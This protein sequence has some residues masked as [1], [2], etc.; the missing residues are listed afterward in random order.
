MRKTLYSILLFLFLFLPHYTLSISDYPFF[1]FPTSHEGSNSWYISNKMG[2]NYFLETLNKWLIGHLGDDFVEDVGTP[3][4]SVSDGEVFIKK[5]WPK[6]SGYIEVC[7]TDSSGVEICKDKKLNNHGWGPVLIIKHDISPKKFNSVGAI[8]E[9]STA[10]ENPSV[11]YSHYGHLDNVDSLGVGQQIIKGQQVGEVGLV[12]WYWPHLH[13]EIKDTYALQTELHDGVGVGYSSVN[14]VV[15]HHYSPSKFIELNKNLVLAEEKPEP[16]QDQ[17]PKP[18]F[19]SFLKNPLDIFSVFLAKKDAD[20]KGEKVADEKNQKAVEQEAITQEESQTNYNAQIINSSEKFTALPVQEIQITISAQNTGTTPWLQKNVSIN[21]ALGEALNAKFKHSSWLTNLRTTRLDQS[22][23]N[24][25]ETGTFS[26]SIT[27]PQTLGDHTFKSFL[28]LQ[29]GSSFTSIGTGIYTATIQVVEKIEQESQKTPVAENPQKNTFTNILGDTLKKTQE[30]SKQVVDTIIDTIKKIP[31]LIP[32]INFSSGSGSG[33]GSSNQTSLEVTTTTIGTTT[34]TIP[35]DVVTTTTT[36]TTTT[37]TTTTPPT[38]PDDP[39]QGE[40]ETG[41]EFP[42]LWITVTGADTFPLTTTATTTTILGTKSTA[43]ET[44]FVNDVT[45]DTEDMSSST[46]EFETTLSEGLNIFQFFVK[47][48]EGNPTSTISIEIISDTTAPQIPNVILTQ[49]TFA[50]PTM[51]ISWSSEGGIYYDV[52]LKEFDDADWTSLFE[53]TSTTETIIDVERYGTYQVR[54]RARDALGNI[55]EWSEPVSFTVDWSKTLVLNE[56]NWIGVGAS[57]N[58]CKNPEWIELYN[59]SNEV[60]DL[61]GWSLKVNSKNTTFSILLAGMLEAH[62]YYLIENIENVISTMSANALFPSKTSLPDTG[63]YLAVVNSLGEIIDELDQQTGWVAGGIVGDKYLPMERVDTTQTGTQASNWKSAPYRSYGIA[64]NCKNP[65][66]GSPKLSSNKNILL[67]NNITQV[68]DFGADKTR[69]LDAAHS[70]YIFDSEVSI[71]LGYTI[72]IEPGVELLA[73]T[74]NSGFKVEG[75][76]EFLGTTEHPIML[77]SLKDTKHGNWCSDSYLSTYC[78]KTAAPGDWKFIRVMS[79]GVL[80]MHHTELYYAGAK[81]TYGICPTC[82][83]SQAIRNEGG[84]VSISESTISDSY[85]L[86]QNHTSDAFIYASGGRITIS[87]SQLTNGCRALQAQDLTDVSVDNTTMSNFNLSCTY[88]V[89]LNSIFPTSWTGNQLSNNT[90]D[91]VYIPSLI[92][93]AD[94]TF[95]SNTA[96]AFAS[97]E[98]PP[99]YTLSILSGAT[100]LLEKNGLMRIYGTLDMQGTSDNPIQILPGTGGG[101]GGIYVDGGTANMSGVEISGGGYFPKIS[102]YPL[103]STEPV[104]LWIDHAQVMMHDVTIANSR[105]PGGILYGIDSTISI[106][107]STFGW[108]TDY[109]KLPNWFD[110]GIT[111]KNSLLHIDNVNF[112]KM[113]TAL[114][115]LDGS[116]FT[117]ENF[118]ASNFI[119]SYHT[120]YKNWQPAGLLDFELWK[121]VE[122]DVVEEEV[123]EEDE[124]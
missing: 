75:N 91:A 33:G 57:S 54:A 68:Y 119:D 73:S 111:V 76:L 3:V 59:T 100:I 4:Y 32:H 99:P 98:V 115:I 77:T 85:A 11:V 48:Q 13:F 112:K 15:N 81:Y 67:P 37:I 82:Y 20:I 124:G 96:F 71:P 102:S 43:V 89:V 2:A 106:Y 53:S 52:Q 27:A 113:N 79:G 70:P 16:Q 14:G 25:G 18:S 110:N 121:S 40:E 36:I 24:A 44:I 38:P 104:S 56:I 78:I 31:E 120:E 8:L 122:D 105:R 107:T 95:D 19:F 64:S 58:S 117:Y 90:Y 80:N 123:L 6:C 97:L 46:W 86:A 21:V 41:Q 87:S 5:D 109:D 17:K 61:S 35:S 50:S 116:T 22:Q 94:T 49:E 51:A 103:Q 42:Q 69:I 92:I 108:D 9:T 39:V 23:I 74:V 28:V 1:G 118:S 45:L 63:A 29:N 10:E 88:P 26:F 66:Y 30:T 60:L 7:E 72:Q 34:S 65:V 12:C 93:D 101:F 62:T 84:I 114:S 83:V 47:D 55:S